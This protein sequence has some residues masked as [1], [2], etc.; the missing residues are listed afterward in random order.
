MS[1][2]V[3]AYKRLKYRPLSGFKGRQVTIPAFDAIEKTL[4]QEMAAALPAQFSLQSRFP[5]MAMVMAKYGSLDLIFSTPAPVLTTADTIT[6]DGLRTLGLVESEGTLAEEF[7]WVERSLTDNTCFLRVFLDGWTLQ[8]VIEIKSELTQAQKAKGV[9][10][11][12]AYEAAV[13]YLAENIRQWFPLTFTV[14]D[15]CLT[16]STSIWVSSHFYL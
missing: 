14:D 11:A 12:S 1:A 2:N 15:A 9:P 7:E 4:L 16:N 10:A 6:W 8:Q 5:H 3:F 13:D